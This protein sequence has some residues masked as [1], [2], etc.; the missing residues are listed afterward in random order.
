MGGVQCSAP[1]WGREQ[2][3]DTVHTDDATLAGSKKPGRCVFVCVCLHASVSLSLSLWRLSVSAQ[4]TQAMLLPCPTLH[5]LVLAE[6]RKLTRTA[7]LPTYAPTVETLSH[8]HG[9]KFSKNAA[10]EGGIV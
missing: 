7:P 1:L 5:Y 2:L 4:H 8:A 10:E 6:V 3:V 9:C